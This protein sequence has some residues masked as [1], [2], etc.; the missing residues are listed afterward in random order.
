MYFDPGFEAL[1]VRRLTLIDLISE[2]T[3]EKFSTLD[4]FTLDE[5]EN[6]AKQYNLI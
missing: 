5:L 4:S 1:L 2:H 6:I 3:G